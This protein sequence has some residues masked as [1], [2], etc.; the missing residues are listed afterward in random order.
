MAHM[1]C[2]FL[3]TFTPT[4]ESWETSSWASAEADGVAVGY[5]FSPSHPLAVSE[6]A[7]SAA[8]AA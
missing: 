4:S 2:G 5:P 6:L 3:T 1:Y 8:G 7:A